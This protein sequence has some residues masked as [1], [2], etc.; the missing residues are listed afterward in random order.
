MV[1]M[2]YVERLQVMAL[3]QRLATIAAGILAVLFL[4]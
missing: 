1:F 2:L 4:L 3:E